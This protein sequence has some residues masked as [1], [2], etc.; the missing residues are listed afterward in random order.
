MPA[1]KSRARRGAGCE[2]GAV[3]VEAAFILP[4]LLFFVVMMFTLW[5]AYRRE[6]LATKAT[7]VIGDLLSRRSE[8]EAIG[9]RDVV[10]LTNLFRFVN[11]SDPET[12]WL[13]VSEMR[14][15]SNDW[16]LEWSEPSE[17]D[18]PAL[19]AA[20]AGRLSSSMPPAAEG[21]RLILVESFASRG[22]SMTSM[23][24][25]GGTEVLVVTRQRYADNL[26][27]DP[28]RAPICDWGGDAWGP[29]QA[30]Y[31][32]CTAA[33]WTAPSPPIDPPSE[34]PSDPRL[35]D[36][37][38]VADAEDVQDTAAGNDDEDDEG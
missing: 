4:V 15:T 14:R 17:E 2:R 36:G 19:T 11:E 3:S 23:F 12:S 29:G 18:R 6:V 21:E 25:Q 22:L 26:V 37:G 34:P 30:N 9:P 24:G 7:Y 1:A 27:F 31:D 32:K 10:G 16:A 5:D 13:R 38:N 35:A 20:G 28:S 33:Q 8:G